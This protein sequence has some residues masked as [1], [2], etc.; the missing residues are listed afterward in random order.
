M[1]PIKSEGFMVSNHV[2]NFLISASP[3]CKMEVLWISILH[4]LLMD[5]LH[6]GKNT[7][8]DICSTSK[9]LKNCTCE[10]FQP[11]SP[12]KTKVFQLW[13]LPSFPCRVFNPPIHG[14]YTVSTGFQTYKMA[15]QLNQLG[16][17]WKILGKKRWKIL[18]NCWETLRK[19]GNPWKTLGKKKLENPLETTAPPCPRNPNLALSI[20]ALAVSFALSFATAALVSTLSAAPGTAYVGAKKNNKNW[21]QI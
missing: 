11:K 10:S 1:D 14:W 21:P 15:N 3:W 8:L 5:F 17:P 9:C 18:G 6:L 7:P 4:I 12:T 16:R 19:I 2:S 20:S 13:I